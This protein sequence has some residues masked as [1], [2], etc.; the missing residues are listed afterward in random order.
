VHFQTF[1]DAIKLCGHRWTFEVMAALDQQPLRFTDL[2]RTIQPIPSSKSLNDALH[3]LQEQQLVCR[4]TNDS[5]L[6]QL[7][8]AGQHLLPLMAAF[9]RDLQQWTKTYRQQGAP[10]RCRRP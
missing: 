5:G 1:Y 2:M 7:T 4:V 10:Q 3:R 9:T 6:Y 8:A